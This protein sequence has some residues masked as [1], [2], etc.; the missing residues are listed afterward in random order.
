MNNP[1]PSKF[2]YNPETDEIPSKVRWIIMLLAFGVAIYLSTI[3][4]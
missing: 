4:V 3:L 2:D 1:N